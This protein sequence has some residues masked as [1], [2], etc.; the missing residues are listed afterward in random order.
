MSETIE[1]SKFDKICGIFFVCC[2]AWWLISHDIVYP[3]LA[4]QKVKKGE[5]VT[6]CAYVVDKKKDK[7]GY[8]Y[9]VYVDGKIYDHIDIFGGY[10]VVLPKQLETAWHNFPIEK[11][12]WDF[13]VVEPMTCK[14]VQ[15]VEIYNIFGFKK[16][17]LFDYLK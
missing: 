6:T 7:Y 8:D 17:F 1:R 10:G 4:L 5:L 12:R 2:V 11:E 14:K 16:L 15:Y 3:Y 9:W 13:L